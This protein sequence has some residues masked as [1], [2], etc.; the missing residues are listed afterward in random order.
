MIKFAELNKGDNPNVF[1]LI[2]D[3]TEKEAKNGSPFLDV[4]LSDGEKEIV[5]K[6]FSCAKDN[7]GH[8]KGEILCMTIGVSEYNGAP[9]YKISNFRPADASD[10]VSLSDFVLS[11]PISGKS[12]YDE[13]MSVA[14]EVETRNS[15]LG[16][17]LRYILMKYEDKLLYWSAAKSMHHNCYSGLLYHAYRMMHAAKGLAKVYTTADE[18]ILIVGAILH[19]IGKIQELE[20]DD[21]GVAEYTIDGNL[22]GHLFLGI[23]MIKE[24]AVS[25]GV[26]ANGEVVK[27][28]CHIIASHHY[29]PEWDAIKRPATLE[30]LL[31]SQIDMIDSRVYMFEKAEA[32]LAPGEIA[33]TSITDGIRVYRP[34]YRV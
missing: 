34:V 28:L 27:N 12:M 20:T 30:A 33:Q 17:I 2:T 18:D 24:A 14:Y 1:A 3:V 29:N 8:D 4:R 15:A 5:A 31:I 16:N 13:F 22:F 11:A 23:E 21:V 9:S 19:D 7:F 6:I 26:P 10:G 32:E 25:V